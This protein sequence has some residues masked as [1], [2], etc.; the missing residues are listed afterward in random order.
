MK[1]R[2]LAIEIKHKKPYGDEAKKNPVDTN[3]DK[4]MRKPVRGL[5]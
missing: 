2:E 4:N 3:D 1:D 5:K